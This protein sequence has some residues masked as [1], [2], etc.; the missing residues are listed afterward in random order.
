[1]KNNMLKSLL[2]TFYYFILTTW[3]Q[4]SVALCLHWSSLSE[5]FF[6]VVS[7]ILKQIYF[8]CGLISRQN[9]ALLVNQQQS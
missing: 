8:N 7:F 5:Y 9:I 1:M 4:V 3:F 6:T 2:L